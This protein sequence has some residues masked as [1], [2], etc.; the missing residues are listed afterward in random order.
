MFIVFYFHD[1]P[2]FNDTAFGVTSRFIF[3]TDQSEIRL[4]NLEILKSRIC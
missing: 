2:A 3:S 4:P 1:T